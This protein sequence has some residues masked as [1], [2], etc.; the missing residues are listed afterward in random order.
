MTAEIAIL[1]RTAVALAADSIV[2]LVGPRGAKTFDSAEKIFELVRQQPIGLMIYNNSQFVN[3]PLEVITRRFR[4]HH[5]QTRFTGLVQVWPE[6]RAYLI[7]F[8]H[9]QDDEDDHFQAFVRAEI[10]ELRIVH[11]SLMLEQGTRPRRRS[12]AAIESHLCAYV[13]GRRA[14]GDERRIAWYLEDKSF[15]DFDA[16]YG[17][18][19]AEVAKSVLDDIDLSAK[20]VLE[21]KRMMFALIRS[22]IRTKA[23]TGLVFAGFGEADL[24]PTLHNV[25]MDGLYF[26]EFRLLKDELIDI[27]RRG[28]TSAVVPFAQ[29]EMP[30]RFIQGIDRVFEQHIES[31]MTSILDL[32]LDDWPSGIDASRRDRLRES[33]VSWFQQAVGSLKQRAEAE[34][35][36]VVDHLSKKEL[37]EVAHSLVELTWRKRRYSNEVESV[38]GPIDVAILTRNEGFIWVRRKHYFEM[39]LNPGYERRMQNTEGNHHDRTGR[40]EG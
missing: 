16:R 21:L 38:G 26:G 29:T 8:P 10:N 5:A 32:M 31:A 25:E 36:S 2:T 1:N 37:A 40:Q 4:E 35:N 18:A 12:P 20:L 3:A 19:V 30:Q 27:D 11:L 24:F 33:A 9:S 15:E 17:P 23:Y 6:F 22:D 28:P 7:G 39:D 34:L 13:R 14:Q